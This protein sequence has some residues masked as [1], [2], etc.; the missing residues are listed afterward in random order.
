M[1]Y[2]QYSELN[3]LVV[4]DKVVHRMVQMSRRDETAR[5]SWSCDLFWVK[6][7]LQDFTYGLTSS[8]FM[9]LLRNTAEICFVISSNRCGKATRDRA[10]LFVP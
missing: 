3:L 6:V 1:M 10:G 2:L 5:D 9:F 4:Y 7:E 8:N